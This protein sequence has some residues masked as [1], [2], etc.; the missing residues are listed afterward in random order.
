MCGWV[1]VVGC[2]V[3][4][5]LVPCQTKLPAD[6]TQS[7]FFAPPNVPYCGKYLAV[8]RQ[9]RRS[10]GIVARVVWVALCVPCSASCWRLLSDLSGC[11]AAVV[12]PQ[13]ALY[14]MYLLRLT[15]PDSDQHGLSHRDC[16]SSLDFGL[17]CVLSCVCLDSVIDSACTAHLHWTSQS[18]S[19]SSSMPLPN[20]CSHLLHKSQL[21]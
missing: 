19:C 18:I 8:P 7:T 4:R 9:V 15:P 11:A 14:L 2:T 10:G 20:R 12:I 3:C 21:C 16:T 1:G 17:P 5:V 13:A 6:A